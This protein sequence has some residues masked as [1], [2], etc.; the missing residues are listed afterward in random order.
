MKIE[1]REL[2]RC[3]GEIKSG[4]LKGVNERCLRRGFKVKTSGEILP[5]V[6]VY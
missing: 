1:K 6:L 3:I 5:V 2:L 4:V